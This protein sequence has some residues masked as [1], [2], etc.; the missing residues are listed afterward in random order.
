MSETRITQDAGREP[1]T[2]NCLDRSTSIAQ[3]APGGEHP[4]SMPYTD[5][6][7][8]PGS[9]CIDRTHTG[10]QILVDAR[11]SEINGAL[12][13]KSTL[14]PVIAMCIIIT[15]CLI[16]ILSVVLPFVWPRPGTEFLSRPLEVIEK[17]ALLVVGYYLGKA[18]A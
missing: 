2:R 4:H 18:N 13:E 10:E 16:L 6:P 3:Q 7:L 8:L 17:L 11:P 15:L 5:P 12:V 9:L 1:G 14:R